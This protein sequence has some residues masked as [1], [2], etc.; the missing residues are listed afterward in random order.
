MKAITGEEDL[1]IFYPKLLKS[2][3][4]LPN[5]EQIIKYDTLSYKTIDR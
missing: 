1:L 5:Y 3:I 4:M 2:T